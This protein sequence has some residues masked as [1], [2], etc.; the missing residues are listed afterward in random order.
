MN[1]PF[2]LAD[3]S[4][5]WFTL[6]LSLQLICLQGGHSEGVK[7][8][9]TTC[10]FRPRDLAMT[11]VQLQLSEAPANGWH[12]CLS[13]LFTFSGIPLQRDNNCHPSRK[14]KKTHTCAHTHSQWHGFDGS[15]AGPRSANFIF[16]YASIQ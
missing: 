10:H 12:T 13:L 8:K 4:V 16:Y 2:W 5:P 7:E 1:S 14:K 9:A 15:V 3:S 6:L 11:L